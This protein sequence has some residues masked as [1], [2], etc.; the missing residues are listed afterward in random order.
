MDQHSS[1]T[2]WDEL[3]S[4]AQVALAPDQRRRLHR[5]LDL[6]LEAN[7]VM[8]LTRIEDR[9]EAERLHVTVKSDCP[10]ELPEVNADPAML[11]QAILNLALN[12]IQAMPNGGLL[13]FGARRTDKGRVELSVEDTGSGIKPEH[14]P[15]IFDLYFTTR[16]KGSGIGLSMVYRTVQLHDGEIEVQSTPSVG[17]T[18]RV[19]I[20]EA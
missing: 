16:Q 10:R 1:H 2:L 15:R 6:L 9:G 8:N 13:R 12:G 3:A 14:L 5:Y 19:L 18:F 17:T 11:S 7:Q 20:P 4:R